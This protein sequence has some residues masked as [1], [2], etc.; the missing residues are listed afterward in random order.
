MAPGKMHENEINPD[1]D[2]VARLLAAQFS[3][4]AGLPLTPVPSGGTDNAL[5]RLGDDLAVRLPRID[6]AVRQVEKE[7]R[8]LPQL[9]PHL[10]PAIPQPLA[11][12]KPGLG[13][14]W[15]WSV[16]RWLDG[17]D[18]LHAGVADPI[19]LATELAHFV[20]AMQRIDFTGGPRPGGQ[21]S[22]R[23]V[24]LAA[25]DAAVREAI[26]ALDGLIDRDAVTAAWEASLA[27]PLWDG[28]PRW[29]H[30]DLAP[31]NLLLRQG[32]LSAVIDFGCLGMGDPACDL[33][34]A[35][36]YLST[37]SDAAREQFRA[38]LAVN[39]AVDDAMWA[40][41][42]GWALSV[43]LIALPYYLHTNPVIVETSWRTLEHVLAAS[44]RGQ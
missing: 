4:W 29:I 44:A 26:V 1:R 30:G 25:R 23:G 12:G 38:T 28:P 33:M 37:L 16:Y 41:G 31:G 15:P 7:Q 42:R 20:A 19:Q 21:N 40:R 39:D 2:L 43:A 11:L 22:G 34:V 10:P 24:P 18:G 8:W 36:N 3:Q 9:A 32:R 27:A 6:W 17:E 14:P 5:F 13:Y 35:W